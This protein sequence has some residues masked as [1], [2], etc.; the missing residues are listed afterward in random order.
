MSKFIKSENTSEFGKLVSLVKGLD[1]VDVINN[2]V[3]GEQSSNQLHYKLVIEPE[4]ETNDG[5]THIILNLG[6]LAGYG[7]ILYIDSKY[8]S[9]ELGCYDDTDKET[10][11]K[12]YEKLMR[13]ATSYGTYVTEIVDNLR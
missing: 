4:I 8:S 6:V 10:V 11:F 1:P 5:E 13:T 3:Y 9:M 12:A 2:Y 7:K